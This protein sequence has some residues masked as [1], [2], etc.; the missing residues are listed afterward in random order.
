MKNALLIFGLST[1]FLGCNM[2]PNKEE[3]IQKL[4]T[5]ILKSTEKVKQLENRVGDL[6]V[7]I[8]QLRQEI[9]NN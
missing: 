8:E 3:R 6:E 2:N 1:F 5:E 4:E 9:E 7:T